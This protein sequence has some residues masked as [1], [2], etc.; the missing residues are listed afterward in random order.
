MRSFASLG[1]RPKRPNPRHPLRTRSP[2][3]LDLRR[4]YTT[5]Q[6]HRLAEA[7]DQARCLLPTQRLGARVSQGRLNR[8]QGH[9]IHPHLFGQRQLFSV[10]A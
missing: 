2:G 5:E 10:M 3:F 4:T 7:L 9:E 1:I 8:R 6:E